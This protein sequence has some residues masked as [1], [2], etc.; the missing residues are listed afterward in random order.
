MDFEPSERCRE[1]TERLTA[2]MDDHVYRRSSTTSSCVTP[3]TRTQP[4]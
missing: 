4:R 2:F 3:G 1:F